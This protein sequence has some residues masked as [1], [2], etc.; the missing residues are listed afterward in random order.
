MTGWHVLVFRVDE[1]G[2]EGEPLAVWQTDFDGLNWL[3]RLVA[4]GEAV[5]S[6]DGY[7]IEYLTKMD[8]IRASILD[9]PPNAR[10]RWI[11]EQSVNFS[12]R[13]TGRTV[14]DREAIAAADSAAPI[15]IRAWDES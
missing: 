15:L 11:S 1:E 14:L 2:G 6:G 13:W 7:P 9:G 5:L 8:H 4:R 3:D 10:R 12:D